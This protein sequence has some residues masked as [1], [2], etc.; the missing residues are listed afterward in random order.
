V[1][2]EER[3]QAIHEAVLAFPASVRRALLH[4]LLAPRERRAEAIAGLW[5]VRPGNP[6]AELMMDLEADRGLALDFAA[7]LKDSLRMSRG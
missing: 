3:E 4:T 2:I 7:A 6:M 5:H 1:E